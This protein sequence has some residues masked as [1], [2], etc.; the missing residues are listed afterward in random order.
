MIK[1]PPLHIP[2]LNLKVLL[3]IYLCVVSQMGCHR[4]VNESL[5]CQELALDWNRFMLFAETNS[6]GYRAPVSAR[7]FAYIGLAAYETVLPNL[8]KNYQSLQQN[9]EGLKVPNIDSLELYNSALALN[10]CYSYMASF[11]YNSSKA[12]VAEK[13]KNKEE[14]WR[15]IL[16][17]NTDDQVERYSIAWGKK[18]A[19]AIC[20]WSATDSLGHQ[21]NLHNYDRNFKLPEGEGLWVP[22]KK[23]P[24]PPMLPFWG[25]VRTFIIDLDSI[26]TH[27]IPEY[28][29]DSSSIYYQQAMEIYILGNPLAEDNKWIAE[30]WHDDFPGLT[31]SHPGHWIAITSQ[32]IEKEN[33]SIEKTLETYLKIGFAL[34]DASVT[35]WNAKYKYNLERPETFI[36]KYIDKTW[37][38]H[39]PSPSHP[40]YPSG[41]AVCGSAATYILTQMYGSDYRMTD[42]SHM[43][44]TELKIKPRSYASFQEMS[45]ENSVSRMLLGVH[46]RMDCEEGR[47]LGKIVGKEILDINLSL[48]EKFS[49]ESAS[50]SLIVR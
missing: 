33:P 32:V 34:S 7:T 50:E 17:K 25:N 29:H 21:G 43:G 11:F 10:A 9:F 48:P 39:L 12:T 24:M 27:P 14:K 35:C 42:L 44:R 6:E 46:F 31:F 8:D 28:S 38:P 5:T 41:H 23:F 47:R 2:S 13:R 36:N 19:K 45:L 18:I 4:E 49:S 3:C 16:S 26:P 22:S 37:S 30:Y 15:T 20:D 1:I 40:S